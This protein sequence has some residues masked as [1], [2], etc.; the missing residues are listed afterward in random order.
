MTELQRTYGNFR[1]RGEV[2][3]LQRKYAFQDEPTR[4]GWDKQELRFDV[5]TS[6]DNIVT[7]QISGIKFD[8]VRITPKDRD[9]KR[10]EDL[11]YSEDVYD[12]I[13]EDW[14]VFMGHKV[15][16]EQGEDGKNI[17]KEFTNY[18]AARY[19]YENL[20]DG[21]H[22]FIV[23]NLNINAYT[24]RQGE[25]I[26]RM[27]HEIKNIY[28][29][30]NEF[31]PTAEDFEEVSAFDQ[32]LILADVNLDKKEKKAYVTA[33][34]VH[35]KDKNFA[36][37]Q[38]WVDGNKYAKFAKNLSKLP[39]GTFLKVEGNLLSTVTYTQQ[40]EESDDDGW[41][42]SPS[43]YEKRAIKNT[44][45]SY[46]I[47]KALPDTIEKEKYTEEDFVKEEA[48][49]DP[50]SDEEPGEWGDAKE[51]SDDDPFDEGEW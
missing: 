35:D 41:G 5:K 31:D 3:G 15:G 21:D 26:V 28:K 2:Q 43:G 33:Y 27:D 38:F 29:S 45:K 13:P 47:T 23:G 8:N 48:S 25:N 30:N 51:S 49:D 9:D 6:E 37:F 34:L 16:L 18:D 7:V 1:L 4:T 44:E 36:S 12:E 50:F 39:F 22:V 11:A 42:E 40:E 46:E 14:E 32:Q 24:N 19:I 10:T 17:Q 20:E